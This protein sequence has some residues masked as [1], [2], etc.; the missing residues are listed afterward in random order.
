VS[1]VEPGIMEAVF[2]W[3]TQLIGEAREPIPA[4][5]GRPERFDYEYRRNGAV[6]LFVFLDAHRSWRRVKVTNH[7]AMELKPPEHAARLGWREGRRERVHLSLVRADP[8]FAAKRLVA[9]ADELDR[10]T[11]SRRFLRNFTSSQAE[12]T[13]VSLQ[14]HWHCLGL[15]PNGDMFL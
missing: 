1:S 7:R 5:P 12:L 9:V 11:T 6:N 8:R 2:V 13:A 4:T 10:R 14:E 15:V 3:A